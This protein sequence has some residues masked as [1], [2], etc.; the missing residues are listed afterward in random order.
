MFVLK[1]TKISLPSRE[2]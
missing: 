1:I 2:L